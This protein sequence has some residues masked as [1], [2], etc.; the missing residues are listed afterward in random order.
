MLS[1]LLCLVHSCLVLSRLVS[2]RF[3]L[4]CLLLLLVLPRLAASCLSLSGLVS[5]PIRNS[6]RT[7]P[8]HSQTSS[9]K[10]MAAW[11]SGMILTSGARGPGFNSRSS[12]SFGHIPAGLFWYF[13][14]GKLGRIGCRTPFSPHLQRRRCRRGV[15]CPSPL[16]AV[17]R[18]L[19]DLQN[20]AKLLQVHSRGLLPFWGATKS[21]R[22][23]FLIYKKPSAL[24]VWCL[25]GSSKLFCNNSALLGEGG[26]FGRPVSP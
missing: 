14:S 15:E 7:V 12:P 1:F 17:W 24:M 11:S 5:F 6:L 9:E 25:L 21:Y 22:S 20:K 10:S 13:R 18:R 2:S 3:A 23:L 26:N 8:K 19:N 4:T 16:G